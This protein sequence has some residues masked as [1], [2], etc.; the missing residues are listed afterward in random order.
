[1]LNRSNNAEFRKKIFIW[2]HWKE[3]DGRQS[4]WVSWRFG[5][6]NLSVPVGII[7]VICGSCLRLIDP[8]LAKGVCHVPISIS[9]LSSPNN[10][11][12]NNN[13][14]S[15]L[16]WLPK[17]VT[18]KRFHLW[19]WPASAAGC[20][21]Q[22][23]LLVGCGHGSDLCQGSLEARKPPSPPPCLVLLF[24]LLLFLPLD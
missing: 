7:R 21:L 6:E 15:V 13:I 16:S 5:E 23:L 17:L 1:M 22:P 9:A 11:N 18:W 10:T 12:N 19:R 24:F 2:V 4:L 3:G 20:L 8:C 14:L